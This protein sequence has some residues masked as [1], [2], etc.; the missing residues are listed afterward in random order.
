MTKDVKIHN[1]TLY[2][3]LAFLNTLYVGTKDSHHNQSIEYVI[4]AILQDIR[5]CGNLHS[6]KSTI[7]AD[8]VRLILNIIDRQVGA[9]W[10]GYHSDE[11]SD[12]YAVCTSQIYDLVEHRF[13]PMRSKK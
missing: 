1:R 4:S 7:D 6:Y 9:F 13:F 2:S 10:G 8:T 11:C 12:G 3:V 5:K